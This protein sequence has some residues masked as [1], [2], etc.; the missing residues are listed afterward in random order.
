MKYYIIEQDKSYSSLPQLINW[1]QVIDERKLHMGSY[2]QIPEKSM[3]YVKHDKD[4]FFPNMLLHPF[5]MI[6]EKVKETLLK[7]EPNMNT[8]VLFLVD[9]VSNA[10]QYYSIP[11]LKEI[12]CMSKKSELNMD[13]SVIFK[14]VLKKSKL[15]AGVPLFMIKGVN[16]RCV[17]ARMD[18]MESVLRTDICGIKLRE[19]EIEDDV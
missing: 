15:P 12:D 17:V 13:K 11:F 18:F 6:D 10:F 14:L 5:L 2:S 8:R 19:V 3:I 4:L 7:Y 9:K 1:Y 16:T